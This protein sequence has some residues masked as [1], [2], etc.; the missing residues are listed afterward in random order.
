MTTTYGSG[1]GVE[2]LDFLVGVSFTNWTSS[3]ES[4]SIVTIVLLFDMLEDRGVWD[5]VV[6]FGAEDGR[7]IRWRGP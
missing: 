2:V 3:S 5:L 1:V 4:E 6:A 7:T